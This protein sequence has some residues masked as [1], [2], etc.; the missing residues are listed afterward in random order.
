MRSYPYSTKG[1]R[2]AAHRV[3]AKAFAAPT[4][5]ASASTYKSFLK[6][7][8]RLPE[9]AM[10]LLNDHTQ[11]AIFTPWLR[12]LAEIAGKFHIV[13]TE[14]GLG[15]DVANVAL[16]EL[17]AEVKSRKED[18]GDEAN[19][20]NRPSLTL[21][22]LTSV[23]G[24]ELE[25]ETGA[26][27]LRVDKLL[28]SPA[29]EP[30]LTNRI[31]PSQSQ[32]WRFNGQLVLAVPPR[33]L[34]S[35]VHTRAE[36]RDVYHA[37]TLAGIDPALVD[38]TRLAGAP[39]MTLDVVFKKPLDRPIP[40]GIVLLLEAKYEMSIYDNAQIWTSEK[41]EK[42]QP[43]KLSI[44]ASDAAPLMPFVDKPGGSQTIVYLM[45]KELQR[46]IQFDPETDI[47]HGRT[48]LQTNAGAELFVNAVDTW[49]CRPKT[50]T[51][52]PDLFIA[53]DYVQTPIDVVTIEAAAMSGLMAA[54]A[55][56]RR[57]GQGHPVDIIVPDTIPSATMQ[58]AAWAGRPLAYA[59]KILSEAD[60]TVEK[61]YKSLFPNG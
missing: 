61:T 43:P 8:A 39:I 50:T 57:T 32:I 51:A 4:A 3:L 5:M 58:V 29:T 16:Q 52:I 49:H 23:S 36:K 28:R 55:V 6:Y 27:L 33:Q 20:P 45:L 25:D 31:A 59:A 13:P 38:T 41:G 18:A 37:R 7:G 1:A 17:L 53:G 40:R 22:P 2:M 30:A 42:P 11:Q 10:W 60:R 21:T 14:T 56:R 48:H 19:R 15:A 44:C 9:P 34:A 46:Y 35:L 54:E 12:K 24:I 26:F 47:Y